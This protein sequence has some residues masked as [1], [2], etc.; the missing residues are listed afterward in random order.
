MLSVVAPAFNQEATIVRNIGLIA[1]RLETLGVDYE[2]IL[3][4]D[5][6]SDGTFAEAASAAGDRVRVLGYDRNMGKGYALR[7]GSRAA[8]GR[9]IAWVDSDLDLDPARLGEFLR[10]AEEHELDV[11]IGSK[12]HPGSVVDYPAKRRVFSW[13]FQQLVRL[14]FRL[15]VRDTQVGMKL[16]RREVLEEVL[17]VVLV[18]RYA[19]DVEV[20]AVANSF[21]F[22]RIEEAPITLDYQFS[23]SGMNWRA[24]SHA[25]WDTAAVFYRLRIAHFYRR[26]RSLW[27]RIFSHKAI[28]RPS[29]AAVERD[30]ETTVQELL[31]SLDAASGAEVIAITTRTAQPA[32]GWEDAAL[33]LFRDPDVGAVV[34]PVVPRLTGDTWSDAAGIL[35]ESRLGVGGARVRHHVGQLRTVDD[36]PANNLFVR[37]EVLE[38]ALRRTLSLGDELVRDISGRQGRTV[39]CSPDVIVTDEPVPLLTPR[40]TQLLRIGRDRGALR[41]GNDAFTARHLIPMALVLLI[42]AGIPAVIAGGP[43]LL[44]WAS[45]IGLYL[46]TVTVFGAL[47]LIMHR[48]PGLA[49][50]TAIGAMSSHVAFG[51]GALWGSIA[52]RGR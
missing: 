5:G 12:R 34:G 15:D 44:A 2:L 37:R 9:W 10:L 40:L 14:L 41:P 17:P 38:S 28:P 47:I 50:A 32:S 7:T 43:W 11:V 4:S 33:E 1:T 13:G 8:R 20:L 25:L 27:H 45:A 26:R 36:F 39:L 51:I 22:D 49:L 19:F 48:R 21:G 30:D 16:F 3:V 46:A 18:K 6:S 23:G 52:G 24:I 29:L 31:S 35:S 42:A